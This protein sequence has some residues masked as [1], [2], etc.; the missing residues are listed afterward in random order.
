MDKKVAAVIPALN[1]EDSIGYVLDDIPRETVPEVIVVDNGSTDRTKIE[2]EKHGAIVITERR[3][4]YGNACMAGI[5]YL[6][7]KPPYI[8][9]FCD[10]DYSDDPKEIPKIVQPILTANYELVLGSRMRIKDNILPFHVKAANAFFS[11]MIN[12]FYGLN[13]TDLGPLRSI[14]WDKLEQLE[15]HSKTY[16]WSAE[17][18]VKAA[19]NRYKISELPVKYR[20][21]IGQSKISGRVKT[22]LEA[23]LHIIYNIIRYHLFWRSRTRKIE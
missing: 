1:E 3:K 11:K 7:R 21:R 17:M 20:K 16:G 9:V 13:I 5:S 2:A 18:I 8:V 12:L 10:A 15:M 19:R 23:T 4:G 6:R 14:R 22:S